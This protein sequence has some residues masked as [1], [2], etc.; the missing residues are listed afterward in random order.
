MAAGLAIL[1]AGTGWLAVDKPAGISVHNAPGTDL[2]SLVQARIAADD[3]L[4]GQLAC[5]LDCQVKAAHRLDQDTSG[6]VILACLDHA[7]QWIAG[8]FQQ[9]KVN[10]HYLALVHGLIVPTDTPDRW[11]W[12]LSRQAGGRKDPAGPN[13]RIACTTGY[14][15]LDHSRHYTLLSCEPVTG[16]RHQIRR[17]ACLA[18][19]PVVGDRRYG[20]QRALGYLARIGYT[21]LA[22]HARSLTFMPPDRDEP[23]T[24][25]TA[26]LPTAMRQLLDADR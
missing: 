24:V 25:A 3:G 13:P 23:I 17:H 16:R 2:V 19:H 4:T 26:G 21:G 20:P 6:I 8:Q 15:V 12:P 11:S 7:L 5:G 10:K 9:G 22:L 1:A 14:R 18:G